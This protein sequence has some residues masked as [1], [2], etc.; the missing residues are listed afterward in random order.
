MLAQPKMYLPQQG[1][2]TVKH[3][4]MAV[5]DSGSQVALESADTNKYSGKCELSLRN[6]IARYGDYLLVS[7]FYCVA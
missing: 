6:V 5:F 2:E 3:T 4:E 7:C 1:G